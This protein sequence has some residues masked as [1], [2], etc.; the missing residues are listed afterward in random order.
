MEGRGN[1][2]TLPSLAC[3]SSRRLVCLAQKRSLRHRC[4]DS[5]G[6]GGHPRSALPRSRC[7]AGGTAEPTG[8]SQFQGEAASQ[9]ATYEIECLSKGFNIVLTGHEVRLITRADCRAVVA[10]TPRGLY[11]EAQFFELSIPRVGRFSVEMGSAP[12]E[13]PGNAWVSRSMMFRKCVDLS[14]RR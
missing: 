1:K 5:H 14:P 4:G 8:R 13:R 9:K 12:P 3:Q 10:L 7:C 11:C 2:L 6:V